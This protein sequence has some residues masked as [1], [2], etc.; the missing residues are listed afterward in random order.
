MRLGVGGEFCAFV[1]VGFV[2]LCVVLSVK[3]ILK[4]GPFPPRRDFS[5]V[6]NRNSIPNNIGCNYFRPEVIALPRNTLLIYF[7]LICLVFRFGTHLYL[8]PST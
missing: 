1:A 2:Q 5:L 8:Y 3:F 7:C 6:A 4:F